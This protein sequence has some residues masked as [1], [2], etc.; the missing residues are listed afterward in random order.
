MVAIRDACPPVVRL[1]FSDRTLVPRKGTEDTPHP[2]GW[3]V[4]GRSSE[5][6]FSVTGKRGIDLGGSIGERELIIK[7]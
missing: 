5:Q 6:G 1:G 4:A 7:Y 2:R 3:Q